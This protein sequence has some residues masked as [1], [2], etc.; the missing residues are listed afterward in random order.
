MIFLKF[1]T[2]RIIKW[3]VKGHDAEIHWNKW[4][5]RTIYGAGS[6]WND[7]FM[8]SGSDLTNHNYCHSGLLI[9]RTQWSILLFAHSSDVCVSF[10]WQSHLIK[11]WTFLSLNIKS[12]HTTRYNLFFSMPFNW[13]TPFGFIIATLFQY[14]NIRSGAVFMFNIMCF[15]VGSSV[16][17]KSFIED[18]TNDLCLLNVDGMHSNE[19]VQ[20]TK[21]VLRNIVQDISLVKQLSVILL[22]KQFKNG[23]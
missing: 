2:F 6:F 18:I 14:Y 13:K 11:W 7:T 12:C 3:R 4:K 17:L 9:L 23:K 22:I 1:W 16:L 19:I 5:N 10:R 21:I 8:R 15:L 20:N